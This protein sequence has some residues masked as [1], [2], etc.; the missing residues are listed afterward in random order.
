MFYDKRQLSASRIWYCYFVCFVGHSKRIETKIAYKFVVSSNNHQIFVKFCFY[1]PKI[2][3]SSPDSKSKQENITKVVSNQSEN[4]TPAHDKTVERIQRNQSP[5][6]PSSS[7]PK[8]NG[9]ISSEYID[10]SNDLVFSNFHK[11]KNTKK[12]YCI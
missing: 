11:K 2:V 8:L 4:T 1:F 6:Q 10:I 9:L 12:I 5:L 3:A 7:P